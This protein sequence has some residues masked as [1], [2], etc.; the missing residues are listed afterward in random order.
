MIIDVTNTDAL[1]VPYYSQERLIAK[2]ETT[3]ET[4][5]LYCT[6][7][8]DPIAEY[9]TAGGNVLIDLT[10]YVRAYPT[11]NS[12][13]LVFGN[14]RRALSIVRAGLIDPAK[15]LIPRHAL[16][17]EGAVIVPPSKMIVG[18]RVVW[19]FYAN[20]GDWVY[21]SYIENEYSEDD[22]ISSV[23]NL[24][25]VD[26]DYFY[27]EGYI[28]IFP[29]GQSGKGVVFNFYKRECDEQYVE[30]AWQTCLSK[31]GVAFYQNNK[32]H[33]FYL[34]GQSTE[35]VNSYS[36][37]EADNAYKTIK[38]REDGFE[39]YIDEL[40]EYDMWYYSDI[41][42]SSDVRLVAFNEE[43]YEDPVVLE[44]LTSSVTMPC[45]ERLGKL[46]IKCKFK[47]YD[48]VGL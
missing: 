48:A 39:F 30:I 44:I 20:N 38:G 12:Y 1:N 37:A 25:G 29:E 7:D 26:T 40:T 4:V 28:K 8:T 6:A 15:M 16:Q 46:E 2:L 5:E 34:K 14:V 17:S 41:L 35:A 18:Q 10:D 23:F 11:R 47:R 21:D 13:V 9:K 27:R 43:L 42:T 32:A 45:G 3:A 31:S 22:P 33:T 19:L 36:L 24:F